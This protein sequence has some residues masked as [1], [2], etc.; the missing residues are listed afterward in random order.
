[1]LY[2]SLQDQAIFQI[3]R[4]SSLDTNGTQLKTTLTNSDH[5]NKPHPSG[6]SPMCDYCRGPE[7][8]SDSMGISQFADSLLWMLQ[9]GVSSGLAGSRL[10]NWEVGSRFG[11]ASLSCS[12][13]LHDR[14]SRSLGIGIQS[15][16]GPSVT[17]HGEMGSFP[18]PWTCVQPSKPLSLH[19]TCV[20]HQKWGPQP[21]WS[22]GWDQTKSAEQGKSRLPVT[23]DDLLICQWIWGFETSSHQKTLFTSSSEVVQDQKG[24]G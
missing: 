6:C 23:S 14:R 12:P 21:H 20:S 1:M 18:L 3:W 16:A 15:I 4:Q 9:Q 7:P 19:W 5:W 11:E 8:C 22:W 24:E 17:I 2:F 10:Q 13:Q